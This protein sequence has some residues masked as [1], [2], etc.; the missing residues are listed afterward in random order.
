MSLDAVDVDD[1]LC[2]IMEVVDKADISF[3]K[4][5]STLQYVKSCMNAPLN[6]KPIEE[7]F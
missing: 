6:I 7:T 3:I 5:K 1:T 2:K 4:N